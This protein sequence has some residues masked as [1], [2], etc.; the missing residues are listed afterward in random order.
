MLSHV[1]WNSVKC[2]TVFL[3][4]SGILKD[5][6]DLDTDSSSGLSE[7]EF[8]SYFQTNNEH[9]V[10]VFR[11]LDANHDSNLTKEEINDGISLLEQTTLPRTTDFPTFSIINNYEEIGT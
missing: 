2:Q 9:T 7:D 1:N 3:Y 6:E 10:S 8:S 11:S 4:V 5:F